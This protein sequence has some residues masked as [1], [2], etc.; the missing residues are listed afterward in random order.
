MKNGSYTGIKGFSNQDMACQE[1]MGPVVDRAGEHL[2]TSDVAII[3]MR[4]CMLEA[5]RR[6]EEGDPLV[7][8]E[9]PIPYGRLHADQKVIPIEAPWQTVGSWEERSPA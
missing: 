8:H 9:R 7:G 3:R 1:S 5:V 4:K 6:F 2:G